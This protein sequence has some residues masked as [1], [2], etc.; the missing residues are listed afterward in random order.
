MTDF[1]NTGKNT[2]VPDKGPEAF[3]GPEERKFLGRMLSYPEDIPPKFKEW[4]SDYLAVNIPQIPISQISGFNKYLYRK[5]TELPD[6]PRDGQP[7]SYIA[8]SQQGTVWR[9]QYNA[10]SSNQFKWEFVGGS[11]IQVRA[12]GATSTA[13]QGYASAGGPALTVPLAGDYLVQYG[14]EIWNSNDDSD[15][16]ISIYNGTS[17]V[18]ADSISIEG[19]TIAGNTHRIS[20]SRAVIVTVSAPGNVIEMQYRVGSGTGGYQKRWM[21]VQPVRVK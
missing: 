7:F 17:V 1:E 2:K 3:L 11:P 4:M 21:I 16:L 18:D 8:D 12:D 5:G 10:L 13:S 15:T 14:A 9:F 19:V 6:D 20:S